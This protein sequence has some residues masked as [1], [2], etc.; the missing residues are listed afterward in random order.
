MKTY[1]FF[2]NSIMLGKMGS[3]ISE[4]RSDLGE[5]CGGCGYSF[6]KKNVS[7][8]PHKAEHFVQPIEILFL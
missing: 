3:T 7:M 5:E 6:A 1:G 4:A 8:G 2:V